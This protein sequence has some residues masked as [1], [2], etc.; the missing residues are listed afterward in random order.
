MLVDV[1]YCIRF[2]CVP[3][4]FALGVRPCI[5]ECLTTDYRE[6]VSRDEKWAQ[7]KRIEEVERY[8]IISRQYVLYELTHN[9]FFFSLCSISYY[10]TAH[11]PVYLS[12]VKQQVTSHS[13]YR[14]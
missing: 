8:D 9:T 14:S 11:N 6:Q 12:S 1:V 5:S 7:E 13:Y 10:T 3:T 4:S 2:S